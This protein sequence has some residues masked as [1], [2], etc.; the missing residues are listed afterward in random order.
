MFAQRFNWPESDQCAGQDC[1][2]RHSRGNP[3][4]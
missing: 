4:R 2:G 1:A 3:T